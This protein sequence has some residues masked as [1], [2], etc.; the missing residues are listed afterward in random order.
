MTFSSKS[1]FFKGERENPFE[2]VDQNKAALWFYEQ[3]YSITGDDRAQIDEYRC[4]V[5][6]FREDDG[7]PEGYKALLFNRY[8][9]MS[10]S[11]VDSIP[12][13]KAFYEKYYG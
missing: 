13:F 12:D 3:C 11:V 7:V 2:R 4:Y 6:E 8:M 1:A 5:K 9:K 10:F